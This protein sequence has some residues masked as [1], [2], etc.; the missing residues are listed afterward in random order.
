MALSVRERKRLVE[1]LVDELNGAALYEALAEAERD[2]RLAE[3][4][5]RLA[6]VERRHAE[7]W[8]KKLED[9]GEPLPSFTPSWR[10]R[11]LSLEPGTSSLSSCTVALVRSRPLYAI[12]VSPATMPA[13]CAGEPGSTVTTS[14]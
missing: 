6:S 13:F 12:T 9:N 5:R 4:Y 7:R 3:V 8:R 11:T 1:N 2:G 10:T 14:G